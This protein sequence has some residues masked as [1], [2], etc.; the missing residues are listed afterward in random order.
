MSEARAIFYDGDSSQKRSVDIAFEPTGIVILENEA[1]IA[2]WRYDDMRRI[3]APRDELRLSNVAAKELARLEIVDRG[4]ARAFHDRA[5]ALERA[6]GLRIGAGRI[7]FWS[8]AAA[9]S[10]VGIAI[11][12]MPLIADR[13]APLVPVAFEKRIGYAVDKQVRAIFKGDACDG[14]GGRAALQK[15]VD[16]LAERIPTPVPLEA[17]VLS[18][19]VPNAVALPGGRVYVFDGLLRKSESVDELAG[20]LGHEIAH[21]AHR[22]GMR[23]MIQT[24][25]TSF[26]IG[27]LFGDVAGAG[28]VLTLANEVANASYS[29]EAEA[30]ADSTATTALL[31]LG[32]SPVGLGEL[33]M[34]IT[35]AQSSGALDLLKSH[36]LTEDRLARLRAVDRPA[37][38]APL[39]SEAE[40]AALKDVCKRK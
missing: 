12:G 5:R 7:V 32:R 9:A 11:F 1:P 13:L 22:D 26:L 10:L 38:G 6:D 14:P 37:T 4:L 19:S 18:S 27:L 20:V 8:L 15:L 25:G 40:W 39:L 17:D 34:R 30:R 35:G 33:L 16:R 28:V 3:D 36:P 21:V 29:R 23:R 24:G 2:V 31:D